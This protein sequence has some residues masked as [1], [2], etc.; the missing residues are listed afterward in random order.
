[1]LAHG[2]FSGQALGRKGEGIAP[3]ALV[4]RVDDL[5]QSV[6]AAALLSVE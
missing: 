3:I 6:G 5:H 2:P 1:M 4:D